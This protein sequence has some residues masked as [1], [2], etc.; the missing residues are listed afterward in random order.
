MR[1]SAREHIADKPTVVWL[2]ARNAS[3]KPDISL[4]ITLRNASG[5]TS[6]LVIPVPPLETIKAIDELAI[7]HCSCAA[8]SAS[9]S[10]ILFPPTERVICRPHRAFEEP[11]IFQSTAINTATKIAF[12]DDLTAQLLGLLP[13]EMDPVAD[14]ANT[15]ALIFTSVPD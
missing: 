14:A 15:A 10:V 1:P 13:E 5:V 11:N 7:H 3:P 8:I 2:S 4:I 6:R 9:S 12:Y